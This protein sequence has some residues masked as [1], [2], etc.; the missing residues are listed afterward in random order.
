MSARCRPRMTWTWCARHSA[1]TRSTTWGSRTAAKSDRPTPRHIPTGSAPWSSTARSIRAWTRSRRT[2]AKWPGSKRHSR[3]TPP[4]ARSRPDVHSAPTRRSSSTGITSWS[5]R[6]SR[7][8]AATSDPRG[9]SYQDAIT[10]TVNALYSRQYWKFLTSGLLGLQ[11]RTDPGDLLLLADDYLNRS[12][13]GHYQNSQDAFYGIRCVNAQFPT[14]PA[15]WVAADQRSSQAAPFLSYGSFTGFAP[16]DVCA[17]WPVRGD[18]DAPLRRIAGPGQG[19]RRVH[20]PRPGHARIRPVSTWPG[21][22]T[23]A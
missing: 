8:P 12:P 5:T 18:D 21:R 22:W 17:M 7:Q 3:T 2:C 9:L 20:H 13:S 14:D 23:P 1:R 4:T 11:R 19:R 6:W 16:R 15:V 10:G